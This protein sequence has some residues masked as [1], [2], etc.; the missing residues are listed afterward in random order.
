M[1]KTILFISSAILLASCTIDDGCEECY[2]ECKECDPPEVVEEP[3]V[4]CTTEEVTTEYTVDFESDLYDNISIKTDRGHNNEITILSETS[5]FG[6]GIPKFG[7][8]AD[9]MVGTI[10]DENDIFIS[11]GGRVTVNFSVPV[12][13]TSIDFLDSDFSEDNSVEVLVETGGS[14]YIPVLKVSTEHSRQVVYIGQKNVTSMI[15]TA[16]ESFA[17]DNIRYSTTETIEECK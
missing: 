2:V 5:D 10:A 14:E 16:K 17:I 6:T 13:V 1:K 15:V 3:E 11:G 8:D 9:N 4:I 7:T 12:D